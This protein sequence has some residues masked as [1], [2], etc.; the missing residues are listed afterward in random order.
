MGSWRGPFGRVTFGG[1]TYGL[2][3][4]EFRKL[5]DLPQRVDAKL[6]LALDI[7]PDEGVDLARLSD[8]GWR[9]VN[10]RAVAG[11][12]AG[13]RAYVQSSGGELSAAQ[14]IY[15]ET[16][17]GWF[18][19]RTVRYLASGKPAVVQDTGFDDDLQGEVGLVA[20]NTA[21]EAAAG[22]QAILADYG[23]HA[24]AAR[25]L[26]ERC[27]DSDLV[28]GRLLAAAGCS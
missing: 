18:S 14:G 17:S 20:F 15:V 8:S 12:P 6:E 13:F 16:R 5:I 28:L 21:D 22:L 25:V 23:A 10:P 19:D 26:A 1:H 4:D 2:K 27:F 7:D 24:A 3:L 9:L 11:D